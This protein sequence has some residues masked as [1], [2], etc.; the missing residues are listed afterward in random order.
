[1]KDLGE[2]TVGSNRF[3]AVAQNDRGA[4]RMTG[5]TQND[6]EQEGDVRDDRDRMM[7]KDTDVGIIL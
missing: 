6:M 7:K 2:Q 1:M 4:F 3:F 5:D